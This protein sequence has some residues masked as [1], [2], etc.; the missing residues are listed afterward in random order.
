MS[1]L[2]KIARFFRFVEEVEINDK[3]ELMPENVFVIPQGVCLEGELHTSLPVVI[4]GEMHGTINVK[5]NSPLLILPGGLICNGLV[6][7]DVVEVQG[8]VTDA[9]IDTQ[10]LSV[11]RTGSISGRSQVRYEKI[12][13]HED[14]VIEGS[15]KKRKDP[16]G[17]LPLSKEFG[18]EK[19][20][21]MEIG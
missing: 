11:S 16:R 1:R 17:Q 13:K 14:S 21:L 7:A 19:I 9:G 6:S 20:N 2:L 4:A 15:F 8:R 12:S 3:S 18:F 10:K 5:N